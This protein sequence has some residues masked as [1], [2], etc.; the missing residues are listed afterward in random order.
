M[1]LTFD[2]CFHIGKAEFLEKKMITVGQK[3]IYRGALKERISQKVHLNFFFLSFL[4]LFVQ[5]VKVVLL[6]FHFDRT[7]Y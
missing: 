6:V 2:C 5:F 4:L 3:D 7:F 1:L